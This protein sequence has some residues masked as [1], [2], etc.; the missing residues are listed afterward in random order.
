M[1]SLAQYCEQAD[2][3]PRVQQLA[4]LTPAL[5]CRCQHAAVHADSRSLLQ[6]IMLQC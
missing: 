6:W 1:A 3:S 5:G 2:I 4:M